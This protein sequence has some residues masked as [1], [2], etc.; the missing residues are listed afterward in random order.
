VVEEIMQKHVT[1]KDQDVEFCNGYLASYAKDIA[2]RLR[3]QNETERT[4][5]VK[6]ASG[7]TRH[8]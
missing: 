1:V 3:E 5:S 4:C 2:E 8:E 6:K 7:Q